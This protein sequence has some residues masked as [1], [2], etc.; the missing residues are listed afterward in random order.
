MFAAIWLP[1]RTAA[2]VHV[3]QLARVVPADTQEPAS[4]SSP[5]K[6]VGLDGK[7]AFVGRI[8]DPQTGS[9]PVHIL[10]DNPRSVLTV[11][12]SVKVSILMGERKEV[13]QVPSAAVL[14]LGEGPVLYVVR[15]GKAVVLHP[16]VG[17]V[18]GGWVELKG[19]DLKGGEPVVVEGGYNLP[20]KTPVKIGGAAEEKDEAKGKKEPSEPAKQA[21]ETKAQA[22]AEK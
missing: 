10:V 6:D 8:A 22:E 2:T 21:V 20:D 18:Q 19:T 17:A 1:P 14:D 4:E 3:G 9:L 7:V 15:D 16:E 5:G 12:Q 11:G 13:L